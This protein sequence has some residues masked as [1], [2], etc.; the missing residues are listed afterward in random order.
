MNRFWAKNAK[1]CGGR[2]L[3]ES[4]ISRELFAVIAVDERIR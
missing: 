1:K 2:G 4:L 3:L